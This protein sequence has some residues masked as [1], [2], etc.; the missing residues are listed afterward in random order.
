MKP[1]D[2]FIGIRDFFTVLMP[3][4]AL[5][6]L[7]PIDWTWLIERLPE[8]RPD[9]VLLLAFLLVAY[10]AGTLLSGVAGL[11]DD[12]IDE[13][14][15]SRRK[16]FEHSSVQPAFWRFSRAERQAARAERIAHAL[17]RAVASPLCQLEKGRPWST[18]AFWWNY[19]RLNSPEAIAE[20]NRVEAHQKMFR[21]FALLAVIMGVVFGI[22]E[23]WPEAAYAMAGLVAFTAFYVRYRIRFMRRLFELAVI[24]CLPAVE[25]CA[26][27]NVFFSDADVWKK[28]MTPPRSEASESMDA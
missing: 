26:A 5:L 8:S 13:R 10:A 16:A 4:V 11:I 21:S 22:R 25:T 3:G 19:L 18:K 14:L 24:Q 15:E 28:A 12:V 9:A 27:V 17:E 6:V 7:V 1:G 20:L 2:L 23:Q